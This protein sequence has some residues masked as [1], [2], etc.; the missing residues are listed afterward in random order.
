[1]SMIDAAHAA[2]P[3]CRPSRLATQ[4]SFGTV[5]YRDVGPEDIN[6]VLSVERFGVDLELVSGE[7]DGVHF[8]GIGELGS[9]SGRYVSL[10]LR[11]HE[12]KAISL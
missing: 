2:V 10:S 8:E 6:P 5:V 3:S 12:Q 1:M 4:G 11:M 7:V 9:E